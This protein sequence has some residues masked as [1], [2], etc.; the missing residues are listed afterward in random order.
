MIHWTKIFEN[1]MSVIDGKFRMVPFY[2]KWGLMCSKFKKN[3]G[4]D[5]FSFRLKFPEN[6]VLEIGVV[7][8]KCKFLLKPLQPRKMVDHKLVGPSTKTFPVGLN[9]SIQ[10][11]WTEISRNF[12]SGSGLGL[13]II[14]VFQECFWYK[15]KVIVPLLHVPNYWLTS[16]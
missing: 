16:F 14:I 13:I 4:I 1:F 3:N 9:W 10:I 12:G 6:L 15:V 7:I 8:W 2:F 11:K 5:W